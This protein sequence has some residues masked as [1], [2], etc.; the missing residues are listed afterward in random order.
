TNAVP[1]QPFAPIAPQ[2]P[3][4]VAAAATIAPTAVFGSVSVSTSPS[5]AI[6]TVDGKRQLSPTTFSQLKPGRY[7]MRVELSGYETVEQQ[8][9]VR[10]NQSTDLGTITLKSNKPAETTSVAKGPKI[11]PNAVYT[12]TIRMKGESTGKTTPLTIRMNPE[13]TS[14]TMAQ[15]ARRGDVVVKFNGVWDGSTFRAVTDEI[16]G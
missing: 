5:D 6:V 15:T 10:E 9:D 12:G 13:L 8:I 2:T 7:P 14:G 11:I 3:P 16:I 1:T 4:P